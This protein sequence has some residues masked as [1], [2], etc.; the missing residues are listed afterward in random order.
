MNDKVKSTLS[1]HEREKLIET[2]AIVH[3]VVKEISDK[4][5]RSKWEALLK[6]PFL[7]LLFGSIVSG[8]LI[9]EYQSCYTKNS[10]QIKAKYELMSDTSLYI[11]KV[12]AWADNVVYLHRKPITNNEQIIE[13]NE[14]FNKALDLYNSN[15]L[16]VA[17]KLK[18]VFEN[19]RID[20]QWELIHKETSELTVLI[21]HMGKFKT[22]EQ[23][24]EHS[25]RIAKCRM[26]IEAIKTNLDKLSGLMVKAIK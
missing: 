9:F 6:H 19:K 26:Q 7:L 20:K 2:T 12:L 21:D 3:Q 13:T 4:K 25:R 22:K 17:F 11:G 23:K 15:Y 24:L 1:D 8:I 10:E 14:A 5:S 16:R 18:I